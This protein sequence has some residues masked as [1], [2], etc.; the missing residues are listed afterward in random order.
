MERLSAILSELSSPDEE[1]DPLT[2]LDELDGL[3]ATTVR[4]EQSL[5][6]NLVLGKRHFAHCAICGEEF[7]SDLLVVAHIKR[8]ASCS[9][10]ERRAYKSNLMTACAFGCDDLFERGYIVVKK[11]LLQ[12]GPTTSKSGA[13]K[14]KVVALQ[15]R[16]CSKWNAGSKKFFTW[17]RLNVQRLRNPQH[18]G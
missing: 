9:D 8:R 1:A 6:R 14:R 10:I 15:G 12:A 2:R 5:L 3:R 11:G 7:S 18:S 4:L 16:H 13:V 17:H